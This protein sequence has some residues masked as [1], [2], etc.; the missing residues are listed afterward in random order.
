M[1]RA[2]IL[3]LVERWLHEA[4]GRHRPELF[5]E[6]VTGDAAP[7]KRRAAALHAAL[8]N[9]ETELAELVVEGDRIAWRFSVTGDHVGEL[10][11]IAATGRRVTLRGVNFQ[12]LEADRV[13]EHWTLLDLQA[14]R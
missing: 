11:G 12:R 10:A 6:L 7:Y 2:S 3:A 13:A 1:K 14:L 8:S 4:V 9:L 5:D